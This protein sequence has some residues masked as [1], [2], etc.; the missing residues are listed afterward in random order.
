MLRAEG[1]ADTPVALA[2][3][4]LGMRAPLR[5][6]MARG[7]EVVAAPVANAVAGIGGGG[8]V[9]AASDAIAGDS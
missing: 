4:T 6:R 1:P 5:V 8:G 3:A 9:A 7:G 2:P